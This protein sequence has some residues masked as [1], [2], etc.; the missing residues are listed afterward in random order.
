MVK[1]NILSIIVALVILYLS[2]ADSQTFDDV[3]FLN[4]PYFDKIAHFLMYFG[5]MSV[6]LFE[7]RN[8]IIGRA[9]L[10]LIALI[11]F[12][13][14]ILM[15]ILQLTVSANRSGNIFDVV[16]NSAGIIIAALLWLLIGPRLKTIF[17]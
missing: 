16:A 7:H 13:Y 10:G 12:I 8:A 1:K 2:L 17:K 4:I 5:L 14:G 6:I 9:Q 15:E 3:P 11:P